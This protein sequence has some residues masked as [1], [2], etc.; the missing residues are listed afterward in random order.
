MSLSLQKRLHTLVRQ[1]LDSYPGAWLVWCDPRGEWAPLLE[2]VAAD[3]RMGGFSLLR[4]ESQTAGSVGGPL[5]RQTLQERLDNDESFV[6]L[7]PAAPDELGWFWAQALLAEQIYHRP[8]RAQLVEW[9]WRP[10]SLTTSDEE[11][12]LLARQGLQ[13]DPAE[14]GGGGLQPNT[15]LLLQLLIGESEPTEDNRFLLELTIEHAGLPPLA[16][17]DLALWRRRAMARLLVTQAHH[18]APHLIPEEHEWLIPASQRTYALQL[19]DRWLDSRHFSKALPRAIQEADRITDLGIQLGNADAAVG[20]FLSR[21]AEQSLFVNT[22]T[23]LAGETGNALLRALSNALPALHKHAESFW[24]MST[25]GRTAL[26]WQELLRLAEAAH[27]LQAAT[28]APAWT[29]PEEA[30]RWYTGGGWQM[31]RA[32]EELLR[33]LDHP[34]SELLNVI[35]PL[36]AAFRARWED[37]LICWSNLWSQAGCPLPPYPTAGERVKELLNS[38]QR[39]TAILVVDALRYDVGVTLAER[40][41][42]REGSPRASVTPA[43]AP[44]P[45]IT[46]L[47]MALALPLA[48]EEIVAEVVE[49]KWQV[50]QRGRQ[51]RLDQAAQRRAWWQRVLHLP[52]EAI[53]PL[54]EIQQHAV[55]TPAKGRMH[56]VIHDAAL[57]KLGHDDQ[58]EALGSGVVQEQYLSAVQRLR[59]AGWRRILFVTDHGYIHWANSEERDAP[60]PAPNPAYLAR[61]AAAYPAHNSLRG[62]QALAPG[63]KWRVA[64]PHGAASFRAYGG[65][66]YFHGGASLQEWIIPVVQVE[67]PLDAKPIEVVLESLPRVLSQR[68]RV[69]VA[70]RRQTLFVEEAMPRG[71]EVLIRDARTNTILFRS[72]AQ[73]VTP[74][75]PQVTLALTAQAGAV[76]ERDTPLRIEVR[77]SSDESILDRAE[78]TL[79]IELTGW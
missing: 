78:S 44:L 4:V 49:G 28:P 2:R 37:T 36:R 41:N 47:G 27:A 65:L 23:Y 48:E 31:D 32:G 11:V 45:S 68:P 46:P 20:P 17:S 34:N 70:V 67:W 8:L 77:D 39:A 71:I 74:D 18:T 50:H 63:H 55:P 38:A 16:T 56:L 61:R 73:Q 57:D 12:V 59:D 66:G 6:L 22:C 26:P 13:Q 21:T 14:W 43:R 30:V 40:I 60:L 58:L 5:W 24:G 76:A 72:E 64:L 75:Q 52:E 7:V 10:H 79:K 15:E 19:L 53:L 33:N 1:T 35:T 29:T 25:P 54:S 3:Q 51:E 42:Q 69:T 9:G 62:L